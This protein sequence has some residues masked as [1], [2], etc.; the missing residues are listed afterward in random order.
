MS[1][2]RI[3]WHNRGHFCPLLA[4]SESVTY[5]HL[6]VGFERCKEN[7]FE[8]LLLVQMLDNQA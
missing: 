3:M 4:M 1:V 5:T 6:G 2:M 8:C 7:I